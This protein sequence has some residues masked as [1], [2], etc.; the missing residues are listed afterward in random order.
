[1]GKLCGQSLSSPYWFGFMLKVGT[2][3][4]IK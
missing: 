2:L 4:G 3:E 1:M